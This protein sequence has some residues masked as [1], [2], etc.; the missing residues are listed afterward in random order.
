MAEGPD[1]EGCEHLQEGPAAAVTAAATSSAA[2]PAIANDHKRYDITLVAVGGQQGGSVRFN[3]AEAGDYILFL[4]KD[5]PVSFKD[6]TGKAIAIEESTKSATQCT[7]IQGRHVV[8][9]GVGVQYI[10][11]G[12]TTETSVSVVLEEA[13][14]AGE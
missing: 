1:V 13:A 11:F 9:L 6:A 5:V 12:P 2:A 3:S 7:D 4:N 10:E 8:E 14:H